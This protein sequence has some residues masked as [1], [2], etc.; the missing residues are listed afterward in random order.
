MVSSIPI[1]RYFPTLLMLLLYSSPPIN[2]QYSDHVIPL[3]KSERQELSNGA[4]V[5]I[6]RKLSLTEDLE[7]LNKLGL[8]RTN[9]LSQQ[10]AENIAINKKLRGQ[11][12][13]HFH[14]PSRIKFYFTDSEK[15]PLKEAELTIERATPAG[16]TAATTATSTSLPDI[17]E[18]NIVNFSVKNIISD[19]GIIN[20]LNGSINKLKA[21]VAF[22]V[23]KYLLSH[24]SL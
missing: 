24:L 5:P 9:L 11:N 21:I 16:S 8:L 3:D 12:Y 1:A 6:L 4:G 15:S 22:L 14:D 2:G 18:Q 20:Y 13:S 19:R 7:W 23:A 10:N 17:K